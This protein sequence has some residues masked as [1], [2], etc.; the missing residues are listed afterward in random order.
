MFDIDSIPDS[1][2][3]QVIKKLEKEE[4]RNYRIV[5]TKRY[6]NSIV[7]E[8]EKSKNNIIW[9]DMYLYQSSG[10]N[11]IDRNIKKLSWFRSYVS[12]LLDICETDL[13]DSG[14]FDNDIVYFKY[15]DKYYK[16]ET[17]YGQGSITSIEVCSEQRYYYDFD[18]HYT[19]L[20][21]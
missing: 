15:K 14:I 5:S 11:Y 12:G 21:K 3:F 19:R 20:K 9:D 16:I 10:D 7:S 17:I 2:I 8:I 18:K 6:L 1:V 13:I 4:N